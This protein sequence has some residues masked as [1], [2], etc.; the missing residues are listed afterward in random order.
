MTHEALRDTPAWQCTK[1]APFD[2]PSL[3]NAIAAGK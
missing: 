3:M 2:I 1:I